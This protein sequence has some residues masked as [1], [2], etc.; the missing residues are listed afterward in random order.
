M[1]P[2]ISIPGFL[3]L[4]RMEK[5]ITSVSAGSGTKIFGHYQTNSGKPISES[6]L[7]K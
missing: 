5:Y 3:D 2:N 4:I 1:W 7:Q 6:D